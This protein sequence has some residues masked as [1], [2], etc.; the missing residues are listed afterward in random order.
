MLLYT[1]S[2]AVVI[3]VC[4]SYYR[5]QNRYDAMEGNRSNEPTT[6]LGIVE[7]VQRDAKNG[8]NTGHDRS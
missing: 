6:A 5:K 3:S 4:G 1:Q 2:E 7:R 8:S